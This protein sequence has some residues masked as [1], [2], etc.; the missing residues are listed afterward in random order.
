MILI[1]ILFQIGLCIILLGL[2]WAYGLLSKEIAVEDPKGFIFCI[3]ETLTEH[4]LEYVQIFEWLVTWPTV[5]VLGVICAVI[6]FYYW[7]KG[8]R[9]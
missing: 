5:L 7:I 9:K 2:A 1:F 3:Q 6:N 8:E 4:E